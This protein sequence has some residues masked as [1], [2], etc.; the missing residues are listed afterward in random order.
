MY[1]DPSELLPLKLRL[2]GGAIAVVSQWLFTFVVV[3]ITPPMITNIGYKSYIVFAVIN[4]IT[5]PFVYF[6][7]PETLKIPLEAVDLF[8]ANRDGNRPSIFKVVRDSTDTEYKANIERTL[9]ERAMLRAE[10]EDTF[11]GLKGQAKHMEDDSND[12]EFKA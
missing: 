2:R 4:F 6:F 7:Y 10:H 12:G 9:Q 11:D 5:V 3:E 8:F 1:A